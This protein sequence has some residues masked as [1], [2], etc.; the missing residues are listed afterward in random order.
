MRR[1][2]THKIYMYF[3]RHEYLFCRVY[4]LYDTPTKPFELDHKKE[5]L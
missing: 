3:V 2:P 1:Q 5:Y 4:Y